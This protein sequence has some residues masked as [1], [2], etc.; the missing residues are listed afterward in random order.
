MV[1]QNRAPQSMAARHT[2]NPTIPVVSRHL[3]RSSAT[4]PMPPH[5]DINLDGTPPMAVLAI[6]RQKEVKLIISRSRDHRRT[7]STLQYPPHDLMA[8]ENLLR[9]GR[10]TRTSTVLCRHFCTMLTSTPS[11]S[12]RFDGNS[13]SISVWT[14]LRGR[15]PSTP[16]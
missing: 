2:T 3:H 1:I 15:L 6:N 10:R 9:L 16:R 14:C 11:R 4:G 12:A 8:P 13:R 7:T 5:L